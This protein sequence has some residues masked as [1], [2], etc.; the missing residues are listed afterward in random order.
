M[1]CAGEARSTPSHRRAWHGSASPDKANEESV[2][3]ERCKK[4]KFYAY[5]G[6]V[7]TGT[8]KPGRQDHRAGPE[9]CQQFTKLPSK[10]MD[11]QTRQDAGHMEMQGPRAVRH[12]PPNALLGAREAAKHESED[13]NSSEAPREVI[14]TE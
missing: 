9:G 3:T 8:E 1:Q 6:K 14:T 4:S 11:K 13:G 10:C 7:R 12:E 2:Q 5:V